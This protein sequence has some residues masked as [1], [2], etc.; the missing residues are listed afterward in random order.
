[1]IH[2]PLASPTETRTAGLS[3]PFTLSGRKCRLSGMQ[4]GSF[5]NYGWHIIDEVN[6]IWTQPIKIVHGLWI[7]I[8]REQAPVTH[9]DGP[10]LNVRIKA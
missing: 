7:R 2:S 5:P 3:R 4:D 10:E 8:D 9:V 6:G 1:M